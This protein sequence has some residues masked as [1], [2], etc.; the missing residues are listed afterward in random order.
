MNRHVLDSEVQEYIKNHLNDDVHKLAMSKSPFKDV[1]SKELANQIAA[2]NKSVKKLPSWYKTYSIYYPALLSIEQCSSETTASYKAGLAIGDSLID[3]TGGFG[4]D[5]YYFAKTVKNLMHCEINKDLSEIA[6]HNALALGQTNIKCLAED[7]IAVLEKSGET[8]DTIYLDP[9][10]RSSAGKV[11]MLKDCTPNVVEHLDLLLSKSKRII[12]KTAPLLDITAG[13]KELGN[14][15]E[16]HIVSLKNECKELLW[17]IDSNK[18]TQQPIIKAVTINELQ[19]EFSF[20]KGEEETEVELL[21]EN[22][23][24]YLYE[25]DAALLKSGAFNL[26]AKRFKLKKLHHQT[27]LYVS[28]HLDPSFPGRIFKINSLLSA[29]DLKKEKLLRRNLI[30]RNYP[31][32]AENLVKKYKIKPDH[33]KFLVFTQGAGNNY[34]IIDAEILQHY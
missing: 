20:I 24:G 11:F 25:P 17:V 9:A 30:A 26:I 3:L 23:S 1:S 31:D 15:S 2:K 18:P 8:F 12:I 4:V 29:G 7:G 5:S 14:V 22:P 13:L 6:A 16:V 28:E 21:G 32:K 27:Q 33:N 10:R 34:L 19:K